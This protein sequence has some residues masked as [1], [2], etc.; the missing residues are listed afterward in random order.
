MDGPTLLLAA[1]VAVLGYAAGSIPV[2]VLV[3]R[4]RGGPDPRT[5]GSGRTGATNALRALGP[6]GAGL[7]ILG[8]LL[9]G[10]VP[11]LVAR[12]VSGGN[13]SVEVVA[14]TAAL[15]GS[16]R[17]MFLAFGGGRGVVTL[18]GTML[19]LEPAALLVAVP[20]LVLTLVISGYMSLGSLLGSAS[21]F[22]MTVA[23]ASLSPSSVPLAVI[24]Y[25]LVGPAIVWIA[26]ADN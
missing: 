10:L 2:G 21:F 20:V 26:H 3:A 22:P 6:G 9:K 8:D 23:L 18:A 11:V 7:V 15:I 25:S 14:A 17:S 16:A 4:A 1:A 24:A 19:A 12:V 5:V 13:A